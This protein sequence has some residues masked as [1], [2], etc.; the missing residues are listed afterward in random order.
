[1]SDNKTEAE[2]R[3]AAVEK[4]LGSDYLAK[5]RATPG[6]QE[7]FNTA[8]KF[9]SRNISE[10]GRKN[11]GFLGTAVSKPDPQFRPSEELTAQI[12]HGKPVEHYNWSEAAEQIRQKF[13]EDQPDV[14]FTQSGSYTDLLRDMAIAE[15]LESR[16]QQGFRYVPVGEGFYGMQRPGAR[17]DPPSTGKVD[18]EFTGEKS[19]RSMGDPEKVEEIQM[20]QLLHFLKSKEKE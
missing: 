5:I 16:E 2:A 13:R 6:Y 9:P 11:I 12:R 4:A 15:A 1:M 17:H 10:Y 14:S 18:L 7:V 19:L 8:Y 20:N 3:K